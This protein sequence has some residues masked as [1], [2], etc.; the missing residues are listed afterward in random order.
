M[1]LTNTS[2]NGGRFL[3]RKRNRTKLRNFL[4]SF[5]TILILLFLI[6]NNVLAENIYV[7][8]T[9]DMEGAPLEDVEVTIENLDTSDSTTVLTDEDGYYCVNLYNLG[10]TME[11]GDIIEINVD[12]DNEEIEIEYFQDMEF[13]GETQVYDGSMVIEDITDFYWP[14]TPWLLTTSPYLGKILVHRFNSGSI[15]V[16]LDTSYVDYFARTNVSAGYVAGFE[17]RYWDQRYLP[18]KDYHE[19]YWVRT[20]RVIDP[21][22]SA[23]INTGSWNFFHPPYDTGNHTDAVGHTIGGTTSTWYKCYSSCGHQVE[24]DD[25]SLGWIFE[26]GGST[27]LYHWIYHV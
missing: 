10:W 17:H 23:S 13:H 15:Q 26:P 7:E 5:L 16:T 24:Y 2:K 1:R 20:N 27:G 8:G 12:G 25:P 9:I 11:E 19:R 22:S 18:S 21:P 6:P 14:N 3:K 4:V